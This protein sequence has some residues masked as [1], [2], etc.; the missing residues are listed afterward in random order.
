LSIKNMLTAAQFRTDD[1]GRTVMYPNG[2]WGRGYVVPD[3]ATERKMRS[4]LMWLVVGCAL[5]GVI[6]MQI[7]TSIFGQASEW[8]TATP[9][10]IVLAALLALGVGYRLIVRMLVRGMTPVEERM[11]TIETLKRQAEAMPR[12]YLWF[13]VI[14]APLMVAGS[15]AWM[16]VGGSM[17]KYPLGLVVIVLFGMIMAQAIY[18]LKHRPRS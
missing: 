15:V 12:S 16:I 6:G 17:M 11:G 13:S 14:F 1:A 4:T 7:M 10:I 2:A 9:W 18:G 8:T 3:A 5:V